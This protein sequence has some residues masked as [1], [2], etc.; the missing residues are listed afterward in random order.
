MPA[1]Y[2]SIASVL[3]TTDPT[4]IVFSS[5]PATYTDL[6]LVV[7]AKVNS[8][9]DIYIR[10]NGD[11]AANYSYTVLTGNGTSAASAR[12]SNIDYGLI[13]DYN[14]VPSTDNNHVMTAHF[15]NYSNTTTN[16]TCL[17][18]SNRAAAGVDAVV[19]L[20]R[21]TAAINSLTLRIGS[22]GT[23]TFS[24]GTVASLYGIKAA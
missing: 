5:I 14:A 18:R 1:T 21:S 23:G 13:M 7:T 12:S 17:S 9:N 16:K 20:W 24:T 3:P 4:T 11:T 10:V 22:S 19:S 6:V 15:M 8:G 2:D